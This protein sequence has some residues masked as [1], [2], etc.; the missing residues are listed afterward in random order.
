[1]REAGGDPVE[2]EGMR[3]GRELAEE[4]QAVLVLLD[5]SLAAEDGGLA[6]GFAAERELVESL[7]KE[8]CLAVWNKADLVPAPA[9]LTRF[10]GAP[11]IAVSALTG[12]GAD[13]LASAVRAVCGAQPPPAGEIAPN[14]RQAHA[15]EAALAELENLAKD[16]E[17][18]VPPDLCG[19]RLE[20][21]ADHLAGITGLNSA[22][23][24]LNAVFADFCIGK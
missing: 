24:T 23:E 16:V 13:E 8:R 17:L 9:G 3:R 4:A 11:L 20:S 15:L 5:G 10:A 18:A 2:R 21:A 1:L 6:G 19:L 22:E 7:G 14:L 12:R